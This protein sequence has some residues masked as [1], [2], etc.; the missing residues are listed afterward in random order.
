[1]ADYDDSERSNLLVDT[2][3]VPVDALPVPVDALPVPV[4]TLPVPVDAANTLRTR[5]VIAVHVTR[6]PADIDRLTDIYAPRSR[7]D[8]RLRPRLTAH[9][10][11]GRHVR[12]AASYSFQASKLITGGEGGALVSTDPEVRARAMSFSDCGRR[13]FRSQPRRAQQ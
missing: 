10:S 13:L 12:R 6:H 7:A 4:D 3:P 8:R 9:G 5:A 1:V 11:D 2:L